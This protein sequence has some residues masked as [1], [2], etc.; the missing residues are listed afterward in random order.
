MMRFTR[1]VLKSGHTVSLLAEA[2]TDQDVEQKFQLT[3]DGQVTGIKS[4]F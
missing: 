4:I 2:E 1:N 3:L